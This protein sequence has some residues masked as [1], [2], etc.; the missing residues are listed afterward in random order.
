MR[1]RLLLIHVRDLGSCWEDGSH[2]ASM[3]YTRFCIARLL[4]I[5][6]PYQPFHDFPVSKGIHESASFCPSAPCGRAPSFRRAQPAKNTSGSPARAFFFGWQDEVNVTKYS[7]KKHGAPWMSMAL[8]VFGTPKSG[9]LRPRGPEAQS[10]RDLRALRSVFGTDARAVHYFLSL[11]GSFK[12]GS[13]R[14]EPAS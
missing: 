11:F 1:T 10:G 6:V 8:K 2:F 5:Q 14:M 9:A 4:V 13:G 12:S 3:S 7:V